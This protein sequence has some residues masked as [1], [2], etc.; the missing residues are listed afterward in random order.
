MS[1]IGDS[2]AM[3][4]IPN[5]CLSHC[6]CRCLWSVFLVSLG[7]QQTNKT[8]TNTQLYRD[9]LRLVRHVAPGD[10]PKSMA[11]RATVRAQ[12]AQNRHEDDPHRIETQKAS[13]VRALANYMLYESGAKD[14]HIS[15]AMTQYNND[16]NQTHNQ[17]PT[18]A[19][20]HTNQQQQQQQTSD[21]SSATR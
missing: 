20:Q 8:K 17:N 13:A 11:L 12:F 2:A 10:S 1:N 7:L 21:S 16:N 14:K 18:T 4:F 5:T 9:C 15:Q 3:S 6:L 19:Q